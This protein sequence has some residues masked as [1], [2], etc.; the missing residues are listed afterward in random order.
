MLSKPVPIDEKQLFVECS[1]FLPP[2]NGRNMPSYG[3]NVL[4]VTDGLLLL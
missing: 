3:Y 4:V 1:V 2:R